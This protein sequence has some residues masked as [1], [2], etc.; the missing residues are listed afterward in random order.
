[1]NIYLL[2]NSILNISLEL[3]T[4]IFIN[5]IFIINSFKEQILSYLWGLVPFE[6]LCLFIS[7]FPAE[8]YIFERRQKLYYQLFHFSSWLVGNV[9]IKKVKFS[10]VQLSALKCCV[11]Q[12]ILLEL[13]ERKYSAYQ[14]SPSCWAD[15]SSVSVFK[16]CQ[17]HP[18][19]AV[20]ITGEGGDKSGEIFPFMKLGVRPLCL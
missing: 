2:R 20:N 15:A 3:S 9:Q 11:V 13:S 5:N 1:M 19:Y 17:C 10:S 6:D 7:S 18:T 14:L 8:L 4:N 12:P 16:G